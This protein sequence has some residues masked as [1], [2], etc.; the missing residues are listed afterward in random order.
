MMAKRR[1][2]VGVMGLVKGVGVGVGVGVG[3]EEFFVLGS[4]LGKWDQAW[5]RMASR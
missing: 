1:Y 4:L 3:K 5:R 2:R